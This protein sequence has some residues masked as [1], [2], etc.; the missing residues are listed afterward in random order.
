MSR[1]TTGR[2]A[3]SVFLG[4]IFLV[5]VVL[6]S[7]PSQATALNPKVGNDASVVDTTVGCP[8]PH[9]PTSKTSETVPEIGADKGAEPIV[10]QLLNFDVN[11]S[12]IVERIPP[13][14]WRPATATISELNYFGVALRPDEKDQEATKQWLSEWDLHYTATVAALPCTADKGMSAEIDS[15]NWSG[16]VGQVGGYYEA[17][18]RTQFSAGI[19]CAT[20]LDSYTNWVGIGGVNSGHLIQNGFWNSHANGASAPF[21]ELI[22]PGYDTSVTRLTSP[23]V[24][25]G[26][27]FNISTTYDPFFG[28]TFSWHDLTGGQLFHVTATSVGGHGPSFFYDGSTA[29]AIDERGSINSVNSSLRN[30]GTSS[31][32][33]VQVARNGGALGQIRAELPHNGFFMRNDSLTTYLSTPTSG[34]DLGSFADTWL[35]CL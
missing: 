24:A 29:E 20:Q 9:D 19:P 21:Y 26:D 4:G 3:I 22:G 11:S 7:A 17:Y 27:I 32:S 12:N 15:S 16:S 30:F 33:F 23:L 25:L 28:I 35:G 8:D 10:A 18:G 5:A 14:S 1:L 2:A 31:W 6:A 13:A 34:A